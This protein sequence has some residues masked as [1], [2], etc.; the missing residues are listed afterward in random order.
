[1]AAASA[2]PVRGAR[3][4][5]PI[6]AGA[7]ARARRDFLSE[8]LADL[9]RHHRRSSVCAIVATGNA[10]PKPSPSS[11]A[12]HPRRR[13]DSRSSSRVD[14]D[15]LRAPSW[16]SSARSGGCREPVHQ[17]R[18]IALRLARPR[19]A[20]ASSRSTSSSTPCPRWA[21]CSTRSRRAS[22]RTGLQLRRLHDRRSSGRASRP[23]PA[24][25][26]RPPQ[27]LGMPERLIDASDRPAAGRPHRHPGHRQR[28]RVD[29]Q[30]Q[31]A[32]LAW[33]GCR[34]SSGGPDTVG[35]SNQQIVQ[36]LLIAALVYWVLTIIF[37]YFQARL[38]KRMAKGDR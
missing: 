4:W 32:G 9:G 22:S 30:G 27:A 33:S 7:A 25:S 15:H 5:T 26:A 35:R 10:D 36:A 17:R 34:S 14:V 13:P 16:P 20:A 28:L 3:S 2:R 6:A 8:V 12:V 1:M 21:S 19:H 29:D 24:A 38:E 37:S 31:L 18:R 11:G 23:C